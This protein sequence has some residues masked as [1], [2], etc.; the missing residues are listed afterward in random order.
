MKVSSIIFVVH[1]KHILFLPSHLCGILFL[2]ILVSFAFYEKE[3]GTFNNLPYLFQNGGVEKG[4]GKWTRNFGKCNISLIIKHSP[5]LILLL[6]LLLLG[7]I[8]TRLDYVHSVS[9]G[10]KVILLLWNSWQRMRW[11]RFEGS[12]ILFFRTSEYLGG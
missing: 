8:I 4:H 1:R 11:F 2:V 7:T 5:I 3:N 10:R 6:Q 12:D 9:F